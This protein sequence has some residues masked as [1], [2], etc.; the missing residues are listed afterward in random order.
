MAAII[1]M[2]SVVVW[3]RRSTLIRPPINHLDTLVLL[4]AIVASVGFSSSLSFSASSVVPY[5]LYHRPTERA[6][7]LKKTHRPQKS[8]KKW[9]RKH[10][11]SL[12]EAKWVCQTPPFASF[13]CVSAFWPKSSGGVLCVADGFDLNR[14]SKGKTPLHVALVFLRTN[15]WLYRTFICCIELSLSRGKMYSAF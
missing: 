15:C 4:L 11:Q 6:L 13:L 12:W 7:A 10:P 8:R 5:P 3:G 14:D 2:V 1:F 9:Q